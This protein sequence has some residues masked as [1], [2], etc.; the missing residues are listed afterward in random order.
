[1]AEIDG[2]VELGEKRRGKRTILVKTEGGQVVEHLVPARQAP[3]RPLAATASA[4]A[5]RSSTARS[6]RTT[7]CASRATRRCRTTCSREVQNVYR[8]QNVTIDDKH[9]EIIISQMLRKVRVEDP[10]DTDLLPGMRRRQVPLPPQE[11]EGHRGGRQAGDGR[12]AAAGHHEGLAPER[13]LHLGGLAS[14]RPRRS[15]PRRRSPAASTTSSASR[16]TSSSAT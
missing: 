8:S 2:V 15:S 12:A 6:S 9:L 16:R 3:A 5:T 11:P 7:S 1:M 10:G 4:P 14:R 13:V